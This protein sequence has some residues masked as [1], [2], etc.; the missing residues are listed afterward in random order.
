MIFFKNSADKDDKDDK[1]V[2]I[3]P[4]LYRH[5]LIVNKKFTKLY[6]VF[7]LKNRLFPLLY[8]NIFLKELF[9]L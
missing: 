5:C 3:L 6:N 4:S 8:R 1:G 7:T 2:Y 9:Y